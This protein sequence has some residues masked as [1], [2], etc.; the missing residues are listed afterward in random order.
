MAFKKKKRKKKNPCSC[1][2]RGESEVFNVCRTSVWG[3]EN[4]LETDSGSGYTTS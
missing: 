2:G 1:W 3:E 4:V